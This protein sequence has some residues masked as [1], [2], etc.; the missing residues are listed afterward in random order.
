LPRDVHSALR[1][2]PACPWGQGRTV[3]R[4]EDAPGAVAPGPARSRRNS[5]GMIK[6]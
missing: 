3:S 1:W 6:A 2:H 4:A 5:G